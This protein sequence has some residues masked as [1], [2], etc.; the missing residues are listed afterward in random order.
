MQYK[1]Y[2]AAVQFDDEAS[3]RNS[4]SSNRRFTTRWTTISTSANSGAKNLSGRARE[5]ANRVQCLSNLRQLT[6]GWIDPFTAEQLAF[7]EARALD[8]LRALKHLTG[9]ARAATT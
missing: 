2:K 5:S 7:I 1:G 4:S 8:A 3:K 9:S 6:T